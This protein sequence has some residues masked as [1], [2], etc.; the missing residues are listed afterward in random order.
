[1][2]SKA[3][4]GESKQGSASR[5]RL[6]FL[7]GTPGDDLERVIRQRPVQRPR[8]ILR[9][10]H[11]NVA[12]LILRQDHRHDL[13]WIGSTMA[14]GAVLRRPYWGARVMVVSELHCHAVSEATGARRAETCRFRP[15]PIPAQMPAMPII[16]KKTP[17]ALYP[18][19][20]A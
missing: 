16:R 13:A 18:P 7:V 5:S 1:M 19:V 10:P 6:I 8:L 20:Q 12:L 11:P 15:A 2:R 3:E 14:F 17:T 9:C 4:V